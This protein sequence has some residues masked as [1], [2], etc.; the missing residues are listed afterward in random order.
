MISNPLNSDSRGTWLNDAKAD[1]DKYGLSNIE[2]IKKYFD[3][4]Y[5]INIKIM[6]RII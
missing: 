3:D 2:E 4:K 6:K 1:F 5:Y